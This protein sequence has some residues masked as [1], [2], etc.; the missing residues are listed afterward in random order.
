VRASGGLDLVRP[1][2]PLSLAP[3]DRFEVAWSDA[4]ADRT[5][6]SVFLARDGGVVVRELA[7]LRSTGDP[8]ADVF[9]SFLTSDVAPGGYVF[10]LRSFNGALESRSA[11]V[12]V[13]AGGASGPRSGCC[14]S[15]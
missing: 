8:S 2:A 1:E 11:A 14:R 9:D 10:L 15:I 4:R 13:R 5:S 7:S 6:V 3:G 12:E